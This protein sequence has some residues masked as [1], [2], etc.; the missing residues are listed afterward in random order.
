[1]SAGIVSGKFDSDGEDLDAH[2]DA[3]CFLDLEIALD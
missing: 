1:M 3:G 2:D